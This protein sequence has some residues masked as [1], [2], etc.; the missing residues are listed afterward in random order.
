VLRVKLISR[1]QL[2]LLVVVFVATFIAKVGKI[3]LWAS[4]RLVIYLGK[5]GFVKSWMEHHFLKNNEVF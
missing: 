2:R 5:L 3:A 1:K 4:R